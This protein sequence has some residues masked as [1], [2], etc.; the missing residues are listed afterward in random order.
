[1]SCSWTGVSISLR[2]GH[3]S[4]LPVRLSWSAW[5]DGRREVGRV[6][7]HLLRG[8]AGRHRD[9]V[10]GLDLEARDVH[11]P[12]VDVEVAVADELACLSARGGESEAVDDVVEPCLEHPQQGLA[13]DPRALRGLRVVV[14]E[15]LLEQAVVATRL[16]LLAQLEQVL[17]LLDAA[18]AVLARR[19]AATLDRALLGEAALALQE[20][21]H[22]LAAAPAALGSERAGH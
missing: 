22:A 4:T 10:V 12:A 5:S 21:L 8:A 19:V 1:M 13:G 14:A 7:D 2:S 20:E 17:G 6:P 18:A 15:L 11:P 3:L 9:D 16:L